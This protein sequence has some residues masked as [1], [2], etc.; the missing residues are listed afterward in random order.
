MICRTTAKQF[1]ISK[2][3]VHAHELLITTGIPMVQLVASTELSK[4]KGTDMSQR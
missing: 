2:A 1:T 3:N 4:N